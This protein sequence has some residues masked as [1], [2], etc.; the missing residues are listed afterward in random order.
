MGH[1]WV[2]YDK[3]EPLFWL[4]KRVRLLFS[5]LVTLRQGFFDFLDMITAVRFTKVT[6]ANFTIFAF[7]G[8]LAATVTA[9][10]VLLVVEA[11]ISL[12]SV[13]PE[14]HKT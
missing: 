2:T 7:V 13:P 14:M 3:R 10:R 6:L 1:G 12:R 11:F 8:L 9:A 5:P 4:P